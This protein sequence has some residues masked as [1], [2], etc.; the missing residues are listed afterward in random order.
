MKKLMLWIK[1]IVVSSIL[2]G[3]SSC[4][5]F[6]QEPGSVEYTSQSSRKFTADYAARLPQQIDTAGKRVVLVDPNV[7]AWGAY[8]EDGQLIRA[9]IATAG[10]LTCPSDSVSPTCN[11]TAGTFRIN[12][13]GSADC[14][15]SLYP[16]PDGGGLMPFCMFFN[17]GQALHG[18]PDNAIFEGN[19][20]HGC[21][22]M[23][24]TDAEWMRFHFAQVGTE[25][26][27]IPY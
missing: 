24:I 22:R 27:V 5:N 17:R 10:A 20:S 2:A 1:M 14:V 15:S 12:S 16:R 18:S 25:V 23:R 13:L 9:G 6:P 7:H 26:R 3:L 11:T 8:G 21:V 19:A 4:A